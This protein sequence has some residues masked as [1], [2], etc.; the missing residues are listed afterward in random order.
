M[1]LLILD[2]ATN[3]TDKQTNRLKKAILREGCHLLTE[4]FALSSLLAKLQIEAPLIL[5]QLVFFS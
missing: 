3:V 4:V 2:G 5:V 1:S